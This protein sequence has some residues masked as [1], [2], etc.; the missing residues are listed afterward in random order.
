MRFAWRG[1]CDRVWYGKHPAAIFLAPVG[2]LYEA[3]VLVR[4][5]AY[6]SGLFGI[7]HAELPV[8]VIG[9]LSTG[10]TGKTPLVIW[11]ALKLKEFG[12]RPGVIAR[13]YRGVASSW[14]Q[15][16]RP[17][18]DPIVVGDE[19]VL[20]A[21]RTSLP[22]AVG[23]KRVE[24]IE[25][26][27]KYSDVDIIVSDDGLQ[28]YAMA[29]DIEIVV[30]DGVRRFGNGAC[31]PAGPLREP[32]TRLK[33]V[34]LVATVGLA[35]RNEFA[36]AYSLSRLC[37]V[38]DPD[39]VVLLQDFSSKEVHAVAGIGDPERFFALLR[40]NGFRVTPHPFPDH[41]SFTPADLDFAD[42]KPIL[43]TEKDAV[44]CAHFC[45]ELLWSVALDVELPEA[46]EH[47]I[48]IML[49][50]ISNGQEAA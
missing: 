26:L 48:K 7:H 19:A 8:I 18:S 39:R 6:K 34:D 9:N 42:R 17:D 21:K 3:F 20:I 45:N 46:F 47:R 27:E 32:L 36:I 1:F 12:F 24:C 5:L 30:L 31:I 15:Q 35:G 37:L 13:G 50:R 11:L 49:K 41:H 22:V 23:P 29:R 16:V 43:M 33:Q 2:Y 14:P 28:H 44:K 38:C 10:G 25:A 40:R 4:R